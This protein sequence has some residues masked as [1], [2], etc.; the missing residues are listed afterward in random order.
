M[1][2]KLRNERHGQALVEFALIL[3]VLLL[4]LLGIVEFGLILYDQH[5]I[6][7]AS[8]EGARYGI[9]VRS[10]RRTVAEIEA[11]VDA[12]CEDNLVTF[13][14]AIPQKSIDPDPTAGA[15]FG[16]DLTVDVRFHYDFLILPG[17]LNSLF[18]GIE[19][20]AHTTMKYE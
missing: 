20:T 11:V 16:D 2:R 4:L 17:F 9:V 14:S 15:L 10:T 7:N 18:G 19:L 3:P 5:V 6:T 1:A 12:Y 13:G 8:R